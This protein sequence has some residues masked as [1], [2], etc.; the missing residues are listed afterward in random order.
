MELYLQLVANAVHI[1]RTYRLAH[2]NPLRTF[3]S[4]P[5]WVLSRLRSVIWMKTMRTMR[6]MAL[7][8]RWLTR[9]RCDLGLMY[10]LC[11]LMRLVMEVYVAKAVHGIRERRK[12]LG[13]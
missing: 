7:L 8:R 2:A 6:W 9:A 1:R 10:G 5:L 12:D 4:K 3:R 11:E 13:P